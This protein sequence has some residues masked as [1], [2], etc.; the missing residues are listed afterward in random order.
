LEHH[1]GGNGCGLD[2]TLTL[3]GAVYLHGFASGARSTKAQS[4]RRHLE[5]KVATYEVPELDGGDFLNMTVGSMLER[6]SAA[7]ERCGPGKVLLIGSSLGGYLA[8]LLAAQRR[9]VNIGALLL[10]APAF[11]FTDLWESMLKPM[12]IEDWRRTGRRMFLHYGAEKELPLGFGF[13]Q[14]CL[15]LPAFPEPPGIPVTIVH[16]R[17]DESCD[18][19]NS[20]RYAEIDAKCDLHLVDGD[21]RL[22]EPRHEKLITLCAEDLLGRMG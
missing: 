16:G 7:V 12:E 14:S 4:L 13:H 3:H 20:R 21:H 17:R 1:R 11:G 19:R 2:E 18:W 10:I 5:G 15:P 6:A 9:S 8:S 22:S